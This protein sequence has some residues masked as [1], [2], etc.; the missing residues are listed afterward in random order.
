MVA[1]EIANMRQGER[2][3]LAQ[4]CARSQDDAVEAVNM[5][6]LEWGGDRMREVSCAKAGSHLPSNPIA[7]PWCRW[8]RS[9]PCRRRDTACFRS[10]ELV[11]EC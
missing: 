7:G 11:Q 5:E 9:C 2:T 6:T 8:L 1:V 3:D 10:L 4:N